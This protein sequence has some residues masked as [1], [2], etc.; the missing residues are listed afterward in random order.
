MCEYIRL[1]GHFKNNYGKVVCINNEGV[2]HELKIGNIYVAV[3]FNIDVI[4]MNSMSY[5][6]VRFVSLQAYRR[7]KIEELIRCSE[8]EIK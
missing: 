6:Q 2:E 5:N 7:S 3:K 8:Q 1:I 4:Y